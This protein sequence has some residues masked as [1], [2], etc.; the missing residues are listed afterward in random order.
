VPIDALLEEAKVTETLIKPKVAPIGNTFPARF[1]RIANIYKELNM[2]PKENDIKGLLLEEYGTKPFELDPR[3]LLVPFNSDEVIDSVVLS[4][5]PEAENKSIGLELIKGTNYKNGWVGDPVR[6]K[7]ILLNICSNA[8]KF[9]EQGKVTITIEKD[10]KNALFVCV[11]DTG[12]G[13][14]EDAVDRLFNRFEQAD[15]S[16]TRKF[17]GTGLGMA[18]SLSLVEKM[19]GRIIVNSE[20]NKG[21]TFK[22][23]LPLQQV[24]VEKSKDQNLSNEV[25]DLSGKTILLAEDNRINQT[26]FKSMLKPTHAD[27]VI[28]NN[29]QEA[30]DK[31]GEHNFKLIFMDIQMPIMDGVD[32]CKV[33]KQLYPDIPIIALTANVMESDIKHYLANGFSRHIGKPIDIKEI[34]QCCQIHIH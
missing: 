11:E 5:K 25:P 12:I 32:A 26:V 29:G 33:I 3:I 17:G 28:A 1:L 19:N 16:T 23:I 30:I 22:V 4:L 15:N 7:Q 27:V 31:M 9:T 14:S 34:Y 6:I 13:M 8:V 18:I 10:S 24:D 20:I 2:A 21:S